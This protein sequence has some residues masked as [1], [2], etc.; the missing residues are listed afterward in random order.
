MMRLKS[1]AQFQENTAMDSSYTKGVSWG[2][3]VFKIIAATLS[4]KKQF[5]FFIF[6]NILY[7][8][9][10]KSNNALKCNICYCLHLI[11]SITRMCCRMNDTYTISHFCMKLDFDYSVKF[12]VV[13][14]TSLISWMIKTY[15]WKK[16][17]MFN[18]TAYIYIY[19]KNKR[20]SFKNPSVLWKFHFQFISYFFQWNFTL[21]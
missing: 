2:Q 18:N 7:L 12:Y 19:N 14:K 3:K 10:T 1:D 5:K 17:C 6:T 4:N 13:V 20:P 8:S 15:K 16:Q 9:F 11:F 21:G